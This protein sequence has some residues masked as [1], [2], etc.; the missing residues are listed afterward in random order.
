MT[1]TIVTLTSESFSETIG[2]GVTM[3]DFW[4]SW[5]GPCRMFSPVFDEVAEEYAGKVTAGKINVDDEADLAQ[6]Y[7]VQSIPTVVFFKDGKAAQTLVG[8]R[9]KSELTAI[10]DGLLA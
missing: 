4:A 3:V 8:V 5:C 9:P 2:A 6:Q 10:L 7:G 1:S